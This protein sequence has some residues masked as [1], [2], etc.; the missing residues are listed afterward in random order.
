MAIAVGLMAAGL[1]GRVRALRL[2]ALAIMA[3]GVGKVFLVDM[4][5]LTGLWRVLFFLGLGLT[6]IGLTLIGLGRLYGRSA[7][8][9]NRPRWHEPPPP[10][11]FYRNP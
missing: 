3:L 7:E 8:R 10:C 1:L 5:G 4:A 2:A 6:L 11:V 9:P